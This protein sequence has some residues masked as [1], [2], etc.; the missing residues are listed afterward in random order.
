M[1]DASGGIAAR[2]DE[3]SRRIDAGRQTQGTAYRHSPMRISFALPARAQKRQHGD[4]LRLQPC[5][6]IAQLSLDLTS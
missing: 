1:D 5:K 3:K 4:F 6:L 2:P